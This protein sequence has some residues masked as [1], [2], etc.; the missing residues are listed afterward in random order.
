[1]SYFVLDELREFGS[2]A[3]DKPILCVEASLVEGT[4]EHGGFALTLSLLSTDRM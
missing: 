1:M 4:F 2:I 3:R